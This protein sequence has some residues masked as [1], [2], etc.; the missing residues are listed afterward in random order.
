MRL[1]EVA[2]R[3]PF[4]LDP[5]AKR[6]AAFLPD[7]LPLARGERRKEILEAPIALVP[8]VELLVGPLE[9]ADVAGELPFLAREEG[10]VQR[11]DA[12]PVGDLDRGLQQDRFALALVHAGGHEQAPA[13][14]RREGDGGLKLGIIAAA[15]AHIGVGPAMIEDVLSLAVRLQIAGHAADQRARLSL[16]AG[17]AAAASRSLRWPSRS[18]PGP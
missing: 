11:R 8:P 1:G 18:L 3:H 17:D 9:E 6:L 12:E 4:D 16:R 2:A 7:R 14:D 10:D 13:R 15:G 5:V